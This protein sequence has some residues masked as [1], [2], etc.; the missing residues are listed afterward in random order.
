MPASCS[1]HL[2]GL[3]LPRLKLAVLLGLLYASAAQGQ[4]NDALSLRIPPLT[5]ISDSAT[6]AMPPSHRSAV[7]DVDRPVRI[8]YCPQPGYP[9]ALADY[10]FEGYVELRYVVDTTGLAE[11][12][13]LVV[14]EAS[15]IGF[16]DS[17]RRAIAKCRYRPA[18]RNGRTVRF[19]C[20]QRVV[21]RQ[22][23]PAL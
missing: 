7:G 3:D 6:E 23:R 21:F 12:Q 5:P 14:V 2:K 11:L 8:I 22:D 4:Q 18:M 20:Q 17:A 19:L 15:H 16:V 1:A 9:R 13:D 10:G